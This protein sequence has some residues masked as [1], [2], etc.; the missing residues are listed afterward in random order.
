MPSRIWSLDPSESYERPYEYAVRD[1]FQREATKLLPRLYQLLSIK[2]NKHH[3]HERTTSK[4]CWLLAM[5]ALDCLMESL[6]ALKQ[7]RHRV[8][9]ALLRTTHEAL[10]LAEYFNAQGETKSG[11]RQL[12]AWYRDEIIE[13]RVYRNWIKERDGSIAVKLEVDKYRSL[14]RFTHRSYQTLLLGYLLGKDECLVHDASAELLDIERNGR[15]FLVLPHTIALCYSLLAQSIL[16]FVQDI[17]NLQLVASETLEQTV[18]ESLETKSEPW[19]FT[20]RKEI[21]EKFT[22]SVKSQQEDQNGP[23]SA[24]DDSP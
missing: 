3:V 13:H 9:S 17:G 1:Q 21:Y 24:I 8:V 12:S 20:T 19:R 11:A 22:K 15:T 16:Q 14:S 7:K 5:E 6:T 18:A 10:D 4:A 23:R 2:N